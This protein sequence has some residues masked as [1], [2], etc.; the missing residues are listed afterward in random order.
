MPEQ[1]PWPK[2]FVVTD[3]DMPNLQKLTMKLR[4]TVGK[5][6]RVHTVNLVEGK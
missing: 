3:I 1:K 4:G 2:G 5:R 6:V